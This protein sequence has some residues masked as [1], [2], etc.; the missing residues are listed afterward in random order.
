MKLF[1]ILIVMLI[2]NVHGVSVLRRRRR[3]CSPVNCSVSSWSSW[4]ECSAPCG[5][6]GTQ[7]RT[8]SVTNPASCGGSCSYQLKETQACNVPGCNDHGSPRST[9]CDCVDEWWGTCCENPCTNISNCEKLNCTSADDYICEQCKYYRNEEI[10]AF[11]LTDSDGF[12]NR[13]CEALCSWRP[14]STFC[15]PGNCPST[16]TSCTC[17]PGFSGDKCMQM[18]TSPTILY[19]EANLTHTKTNWTVQADCTDEQ[20]ASDTVYT[21][22]VPDQ[23]QVKWSAEYIMQNITNYPKPYYINNFTVGVVAS[24]FDWFVQR[25]GYTILNGSVTCST[26]HDKD[27]PNEDLHFCNVYEDLNFAFDN[28]DKVYVTTSATNGGYVDIRNFD[29]PSG[30]TVDPKQY[31]KGQT[32]SYVADFT[33]D[34]EKPEHCSITASCSK[35]MLDAGAAVTKSVGSSNI[36]HSVFSKCIDV[37]LVNSVGRWY[38]SSIMVALLD[39]KKN[40]YSRSSYI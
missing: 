25:D 2:L 39:N 33:F 10:R 9:Y 19:C 30:Y 21:S 14:D 17:A 36:I 40:K 31:Y 13:K 37:R 26:G 24:S 32:I 7:T 28:H 12:P 29:E 1:Q 38:W 3:G 34:F 27:N 15:Y 22:L 5:T 35:T 11:R 23:I 4:S 8:R 18:T 20:E 16:P 6:D